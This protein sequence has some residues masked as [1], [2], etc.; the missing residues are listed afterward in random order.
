MWR[1]YTHI[2]KSVV[3]GQAPVTLELRNPPG[4]STNNPRRYMHISQLTQ[5]MPPPE[6]YEKSQPSYVQ[7]VGHP[8]PQVNVGDE[9]PVTSTRQASRGRPGHSANRVGKAF[10]RPFFFSG[11]CNIFSPYIFARW[12]L[13][14]DMIYVHRR[15][16]PDFTFICFWWRHELRQLWYMRVPPWVVCVFPWGFPQL[17]SDWSL[18]CDHGLDYAS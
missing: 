14:V 11:I 18:S 1:T 10:R 17:Q 16:T 2:I 5:F 12:W 4:K 15:L 3:T 6:T 9:M 13:L 7:L 8:F